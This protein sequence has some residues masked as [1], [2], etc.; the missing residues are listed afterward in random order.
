MGLVKP[1][2]E[3]GGHDRAGRMRHDL[4][5][6]CVD[7]CQAGWRSPETTPPG[8]GASLPKRYGFRNRYG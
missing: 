3:R 2:A 6:K 7:A 8:T 5:I 1:A 4:P